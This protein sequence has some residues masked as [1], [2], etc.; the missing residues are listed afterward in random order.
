[1]DTDTK[2]AVGED[3]AVGEDKLMKM[4][5]WLLVMVR[6]IVLVVRLKT[7]YNFY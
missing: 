4:V 7:N 5:G 6:L 3:G 2:K 1:M